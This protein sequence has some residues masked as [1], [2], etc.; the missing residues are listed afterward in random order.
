MG[1]FSLERLIS[2]LTRN[3]EENDPY[4][5]KYIKKGK[6]EEATA[7]EVE[8]YIND[9]AEKIDLIDYRNRIKQRMQE[10]MNEKQQNKAVFLKIAAAVAMLIISSLI[11]F[12]LLKPEEQDLYA[13]YYAPYEDV[14][15][16]R[17]DNN[18][19]FFDMGMVAYNKAD[20]EDAI[21]NFNKLNP[22]DPN[23]STALFYKGQSLLASDNAAAAESIFKSV[24][25]DNSNIFHQH[26]QWYLALSLIK[27]EKLSDAERVLLQLTQNQSNYKFEESKSLLDKL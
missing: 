8:Q 17:N 4:M 7:E 26:A 22:S 5:D 14:I 10:K 12:Y 20:Y 23:Y 15:T 27:Q 2:Y 19:T 16:T 13:T 25:A 3:S 24:A 11:L 6:L 9:P 21:L 18:N 1:K